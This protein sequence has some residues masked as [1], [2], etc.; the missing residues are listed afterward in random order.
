MKMKKFNIA[1]L[2]W[3]NPPASSSITDQE[4]VIRTSPDTDF[5]QG[6]YYGLEYD[7]APALVLSSEEPFWTLKAKVAFDSKVH[8][9]QCGLFIYQD[10]NTWMKSGIEYQSNGFQQLFAVVTNHGF[11]DW[12]MANYDRTTQT[13]HYRLSRRGSDFLLEN[14]SDGIRF[15]MMRMFHLFH[16][17]GAVRFGFFAS[18]PGDSSFEAHFSEIEWTECLWKEHGSTRF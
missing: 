16:A 11:S 18:S 8:F 6:T 7:N 12:S 14:S 1:D 17:Q 9:D 5:W 10:K 13:M 4:I 3:I 2:N 15:S